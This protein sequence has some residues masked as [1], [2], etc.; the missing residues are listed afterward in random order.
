VSTSRSAKYERKM[1][2][3]ESRMTS[4]GF[5]SPSAPAC[6]PGPVA[7]GV[8]GREAGGRAEARRGRG[9][10]DGSVVT[11]ASVSRPPREATTRVRHRSV[12]C[13]P[14][15]QFRSLPVL[16]VR[17]M[18]GNWRLLSSVV[19]G[20]LVASAILAATAIYADAIRDLGLQYALRQ[21]SPAALDVSLLT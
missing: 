18:L 17:R 20:T 10:A 8:A 19:V 7:V 13:A 16:A 3:C 12:E 1:M 14:M 2:P 11:D 15:P 5:R 9:A 21:Q 4:S 6:S